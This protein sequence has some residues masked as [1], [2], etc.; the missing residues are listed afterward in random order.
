MPKVATR[1]LDVD[2][3]SIVEKDFHADRG[4]VSDLSARVRLLW[5][6]HGNLYVAVEVTDNAIVPNSADLAEG[7]S[8]ELLMDVRPGWEQ[9]RDDFS[10]GVGHLIV[11]PAKDK[12][13]KPDTVIVGPPVYRIYGVGQRMTENGYVIEISIHFR[14]ANLEEPWGAGRAIRL[15]MLINDADAQGGR[16]STLGVGRTAAN[17]RE[18]CT[19]WTAF[20]LEK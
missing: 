15:G 2:P 11:M 5:E 6:R 8:I 4:R 19:S 10:R 17:A 12:N 13:G 1:Y 14:G 16:K 7:D 9:F 20:V 18:N 3:W